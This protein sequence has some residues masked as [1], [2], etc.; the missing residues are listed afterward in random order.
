[1][2]ASIYLDHHSASRICGPSA[3]RM[4][5]AWEDAWGAS[6]SLHKVGRDQIEALDR[7]IES[8]YSLVR[9]ET[10]DRFSFAS[11]G[12][13][14]ILQVLW[15]VFFEICRKEGKGQFVVGCLEDAPTLAGLKRL[16]TMGCTVKIAPVDAQGCIDIERLSGLIN[17][18]TALVSLSVA[19]ALTG[20]IQPVEK[21]RALCEEKSVLLHLDASYALGK[22]PVALESD[23]LTFGADKIHGPKSAGAV[24]AKRGRPLIPL[25]PG[26]IDVD[27]A[28]LIGFGAAA[29]QAMLSIDAVG[30]EV[31]R[32][33]DRFEE[34]I[35]EHVPGTK[36]CFADSWRLPNVSV[37]SFPRI[38]QEAM[39]Y[40][41]DQKKVYASIGGG[42]HPHL[43]Q[44]LIAAGFDPLT[45]SSA[46]SFALSRHTTEAEISS[47]IETISEAAAFLS[48]LS[49]HL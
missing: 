30:L 26:K 49:V 33:R 21:I 1:M 28:S 22:I 27:S 35:L 32:L 48:E 5:N 7:P 44:Q 14:A 46:I 19:Q 11:G 37:L 41:L 47:A 3:E 36:V 45:A 40:A 13:E 25:I 8:L 9:A 10:G 24:F 17:S 4:R 42:M 39:L 6:F 12:A 2:T 38:H 23:Y 20:V 43:R 31:V 16:E 18:R 34:G 15:S 29:D